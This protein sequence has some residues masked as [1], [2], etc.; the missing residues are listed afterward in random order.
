MAI[1]TRISGNARAL[2]ADGRLIAIR[3][4]GDNNKL[5]EAFVLAKSMRTI[6]RMAV[7]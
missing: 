6:A 2:R 7:Q 1:G 5:I 4:L 3:A